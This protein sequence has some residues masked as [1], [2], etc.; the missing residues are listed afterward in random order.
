LKTGNNISPIFGADS[1]LAEAM[2]AILYVSGFSSGKRPPVNKGNVSRKQLTILCCMFRN[3][4]TSDLGGSFG[5]GVRARV[6][7]RRIG[8]GTLTL[9]SVSSI[10]NFE[11]RSEFFDFN[12]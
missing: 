10:F 6:S 4:R 7:S 11:S 9:G 2:L 1:D 5:S 3:N 12:C 8:E